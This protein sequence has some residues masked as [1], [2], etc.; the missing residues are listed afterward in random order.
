[1]PFDAGNLPKFARSFGNWNKGNE[2]DPDKYVPYFD[3]VKDDVVILK[4]NRLMAMVQIEPTPYYLSNNAARNGNRLRHFAL[5][6][7]L[8][9]PDCEIY[10][11]IVCH[12]NVPKFD[13]ARGGSQYWRE[14]S[15]RWQSRV[16][17]GLRQYDYFITI[18]MKPQKTIQSV[19]SFKNRQPLPDEYALRALNAKVRTIMQAY[20]SQNPIRLGAYTAPGGVKYSAIG[21]ALALIGTTRQIEVPF[22]S[23]AGNLDLAIYRDRVFHGTEGFG[24]ERGGGRTYASVGRM[25]GFN[26][27]PH[28]TRVGMFDKF[29][30]DTNG[31]HGARWVMMNYINPLHRAVATDRLQLALDRME[32][33]DSKGRSDMAAINDALDE[34]KSSKETRGHH[35]WSFALHA[36]DM[37]QLDAYG[38]VVADLIADAG[39]TPATS[40]PVGI[41]LYWTQFPGNIKFNPSPAVIGMNRFTELSGLEGHPTTTRPAES[42]NKKV[43]W[44]HPAMRYV[45]AAGGYYD[46]ELFDGQIGHTLYCGPSGSGKT[47]GVGVDISAATALIGDKGAIVLLDKDRSNKLTILNNNGTYVELRR[48]VDSG[49]AP[50]RRMANTHQDRNVVC[51]LI[52]A[53]I[54]TDGGAALTES[55][56]ARIAMGVAFVMRQAPER[57]QL[58]T[59]HAFLPP[60]K[61]DPSDAANR[62]KPWCRG[63]RLGWA[64]DGEF[65]GLDFSGRIAGVDYTELLDD[66]NVWSVAAGYLFHLAKKKMDGRRFIF[67]VEE[68]KF[69]LESE[70]CV[71]NFVDFLL[72]GRKNNVLFWPVIQQPEELF[73][74]K[75]GPTILNQCRTRKLF[76]NEL[77]NREAYCGGGKYGDGLHCTPQEYRQIRETMAVG[78]WSVLIQRPSKSVLC[79]FD[80][81]AMPEDISIVSGTP[82]SVKHWDEL[83]EQRKKFYETLPEA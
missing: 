38:S 14:F 10:E 83:S 18:I 3:H 45:N 11:H 66:P 46:H 64:F 69:L 50:L 76:K 44:G 73:N 49:A 37:E 56:K 68:L 24:I 77:A 78:T 53:M 47:S 7:L 16:L 19:F 21:K 67:V 27:Y 5:L 32:A 39:A 41:A 60:A 55:A 79:R 82:A 52:Y 13:G 70:I 4:D 25:Y 72:T 8:A 80:L 51:D 59:V 26:S 57:R 31:L 20:R 23:P 9:G 34:L 42:R 17:R 6:Q 30:V 58:G 15:E 81:S 75:I 71:K 61:Q 35:V 48:G 29:F 54:M 65:D 43:R 62:L 33:A 36:D 1:M 2:T 12:D 74:H 40:L 63:E 28:S 22:T